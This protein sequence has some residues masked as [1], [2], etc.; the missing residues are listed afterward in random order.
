MRTYTCKN[1][2]IGFS[3]TTDPSRDVCSACRRKLVA[4]GGVKFDMGK[5]RWDL[6]PGDSLEEIVKVLTYGAQ[7]YEERNW[8]A[9]MAWHRPFGACMRH[10]WAWW[11]GEDYDKDTGLH[12]LSHAGCCILFLLSYAIRT[13]NGQLPAKM[14]DRFILKTPSPATH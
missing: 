8:E 4:E 1:C 13:K 9:G 14:D 10:M 11:R 5:P 3:K 12:H 2:G 7:K 6:L